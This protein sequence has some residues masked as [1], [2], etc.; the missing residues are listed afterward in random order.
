M[1]QILKSIGQSDKNFDPLQ[2]YGATW[3]YGSF[4]C[5]AFPDTGVDPKE[6]FWLCTMRGTPEHVKSKSF[7]S[8]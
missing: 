3:D 5:W 4:M 6:A 1:A 7:P 8:L 2:G